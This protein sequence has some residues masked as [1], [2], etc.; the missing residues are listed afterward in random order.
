MTALIALL[1]LIGGVVLWVFLA[2]QPKHANKKLVAVFNFMFIAVC[3]MLSTG[4]AATVKSSLGGTV[5]ERWVGPVSG[6]G[7]LGVEIVILTA[8]FFLRNFWI[9]K[10]PKMPFR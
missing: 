3:L 4:W 10:P 1:T 7:A 2:Y 8:G 5:D 6:A 9:F